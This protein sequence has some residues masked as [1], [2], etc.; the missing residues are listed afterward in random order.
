MGSLQFSLFF[1]ALLVGYVLVHLRMIRFE[2]HLQK[3]AGIRSLDDRLRTLDDRLKHVADAFEKV[4]FDRVS[5]Q[6]E[7]LHTDLQDLQEST[8]DVRQAIV[9]LPAVSSV[10]S[11]GGSAGE[12]QRIVDGDERVHM[13]PRNESPATRI[14]AMIETRLIQLGY[15]HL[16]LLGDLGDVQMADEVEVQIEAER[17]GMPFKGRVL[18]RNGSVCDVNVQ[19]VAQAFP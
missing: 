3:L 1:A 12:S 5:T 2:E 11:S 19:S 16:R 17:N 6:L 18:V 9:Q 14:V 4:S 8:V 7:R 13:I 15:R 10:A